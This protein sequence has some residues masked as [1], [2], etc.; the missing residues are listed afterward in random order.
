MAERR[1]DGSKALLREGRMRVTDVA[2]EVG[3]SGH[4]HFSTTF[5][6]LTG[7]SPRVFAESA[8]A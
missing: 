7:T 5:K 3:F 6:A 4:A 1:I 2:Y 8:A